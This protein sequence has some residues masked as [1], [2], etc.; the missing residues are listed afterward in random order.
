[1]AHL[2]Q[3]HCVCCGNLHVWPTISSSTTSQILTCL[4]SCWPMILSALC[5]SVTAW[6]GLELSTTDVQDCRLN[7]PFSITLT[8]MCVFFLPSKVELELRAQVRLFRELTGH[9]PHHMDGHQHIH[10]L[11]GN[12]HCDCYRTFTNS[13]WI[14][15]WQNSNIRLSGFWSSQVM[16]WMMCANPVW[17]VTLHIVIMS[18]VCDLSQIKPSPTIQSIIGQTCCGPSTMCHFREDESWV[19]TWTWVRRWHVGDLHR[20]PLSAWFVTRLSYILMEKKTQAK[21]KHY[22]LNF[23]SATMGQRRQMLSSVRHHMHTYSQNLVAIAP[24]GLMTLFVYISSADSMWLLLCWSCKLKVKSCS[25]HPLLS[26]MEEK[27][28]WP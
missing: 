12:T 28:Q 24:S 15:E 27:L 3:Q 23:Y 17:K 26:S 11:P 13:A 9:L 2:T 4:R 21:Q 7:W 16:K 19:T 1:M 8:S 18:C 20:E 14:E 6:T 5:T 25:P 10:V 22:Y